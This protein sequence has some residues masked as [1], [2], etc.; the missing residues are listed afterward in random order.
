M[1]SV[2]PT[3]ITKSFPLLTKFVANPTTACM[4][5]LA[6]VLLV[7][8]NFNSHVCTLATYILGHELFM[9]V[10]ELTEI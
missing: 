2:T 3:H 5:D 4:S 10:H 8:T 6:H 9:Y 7:H 1:S